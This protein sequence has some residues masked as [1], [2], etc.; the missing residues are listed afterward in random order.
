MIKK[1]MSK[2]ISIFGKGIPVFMIALI[3]VIGLATAVLVPYL[4]NLVT[5]TFGV[6]QP[7]MLEI[8]DD[9]TSW[10]DSVTLDDTIGGGDFNF[11]VRSTYNGEV[12]DTINLNIATEI[13]ND[14]TNAECGD[15]EVLDIKSPTAI[16][17]NGD[18]TNEIPADT[19]ISI[20]PI[21][22]DNAG[23]AEVVIPAKFGYNAEDMVQE[24]EARG[25]FKLS[26][27][28][29]NYSIGIVAKQ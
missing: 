17:L 2:K 11:M 5:A 8:S 16:D 19:W 22:L 13:S 20:L 27:Q 15:F 29:A 7:M 4:S 12:G 1:L 6:E 26:V 25:T 9:G 10:A 18:G 23:V 24:Y 28:P 14:N 21:C 3:A